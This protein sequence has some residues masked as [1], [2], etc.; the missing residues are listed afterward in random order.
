MEQTN[1]FCYNNYLALMTELSA[2]VKSGV[3]GARENMEYVSDHFLNFFQYVKE[4]CVSELGIHLAS[5]S[6]EGAAKQDRI[7]EL[8]RMRSRHHDA[9]IASALA[10]N[11]IAAAYD[12][13]PIY[14]GNPAVRRQVAAFCMETV[15]VLFENRR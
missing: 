7:T 13:G 6:L 4:V 15:S 11:R 3:P 12:I 1:Y 14:T 9:A 8:D 5:G 10:I 2:R